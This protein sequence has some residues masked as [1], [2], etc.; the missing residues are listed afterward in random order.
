MFQLIESRDV[1]YKQLIEIKTSTKKS[2]MCK[3][4]MKAN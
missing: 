3:K 1:E 2:I 4:D